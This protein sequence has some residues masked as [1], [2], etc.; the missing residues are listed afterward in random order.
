MQIGAMNHPAFEV[1]DEIEWIAAMK[2]DFLDFTMEP[3]LA[4]SWQVDPG[5]IADSLRRHRLGV[6]GH[7]AYYLP[8]ASPFPEVRRT[9]LA[10]FLR[11]MDVFSAVG[12]K[13][14][15]LHPD[16]DRPLHSKEFCIDRN[17]EV[18]GE[19]TAK[20]RGLGMGI[21]LENVPGD[22]FNSAEDLGILLDAYPELGLHLDIGHCNL[23]HIPRNAEGI[24]N[25]YADRLQHVHLHD[26]K[27]GTADLHLPL[28]AGTMD[29]QRALRALKA[30]GY[31]GTI[32]LEVFSADRHYLSYSR[33][34][35]RRMWD[36]GD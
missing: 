3:P 28:G 1:T 20:A 11:C 6:V 27:G 17:L 33:E 21:M 7:T 25:R 4:G 9:S 5:K 34:L 24:L 19:L 12:A 15:N 14:M 31:D 18:I 30:S 35:L 16:T 26:N 22:D 23:S 13:W 32:T 36:A 2:L 8:I 29:L 10:E